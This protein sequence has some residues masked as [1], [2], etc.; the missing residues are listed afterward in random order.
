MMT[1][2][3]TV[4]VGDLFKAEVL[5]HYTPSTDHHA[6]TVLRLCKPLVEKKSSL[7]LYANEKKKGVHP[8]SG[9]FSVGENQQQS[10]EALFKKYSTEKEETKRRRIE[11][12]QERL[13]LEK[14]RIEEARAERDMQ[15][16]LMMTLINHLNNK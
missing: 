15:H 2:S 7:I 4:W 10:M 5:E 16:Q 11:L 12:E 14:Q 1:S 8:L 6:R 9:R 3:S 13:A